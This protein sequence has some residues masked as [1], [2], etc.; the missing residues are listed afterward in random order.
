M[1]INCIQFARYWLGA[2]AQLLDFPN[3]LLVLEKTVDL[4]HDR[5]S[6]LTVGQNLT[7]VFDEIQDVRPSG[8]RGASV[9]RSYR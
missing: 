1:L 7:W 4:R 9:T 6:L 5:I 8:F 2:Y 3:G